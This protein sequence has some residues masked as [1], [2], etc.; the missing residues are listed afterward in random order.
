MN[1]NA[2]SAQLPNDQ[3]FNWNQ[4]NSISGM[5]SYPDPSGGFSP[6]LYNSMIS[7]PNPPDSSNQLTRRPQGQQVVARGVYN[8]VGNEKWNG[9]GD[10]FPQPVREEGWNNNDDE[11]LAQ[12]ALVAKREAQA[13]RKSIP[14]FVQKLSR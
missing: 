14:P 8:G 5:E 2:N 6:N 3:L 11:A 4:G 10:D 9:T 7:S 13:K 12:R 1:Y